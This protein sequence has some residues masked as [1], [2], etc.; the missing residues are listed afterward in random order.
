[1]SG[2]RWEAVLFD[3]DGTLADTVELILRCYR[4]TMRTHLGQSP[5]D[6]AWLRTMGTPLTEQFKEFARSHDEALAMLETYVTY[7]RSVHD[8]YVRP[9]PGVVEVAEGLASDGVPMAVVTSKRREMAVRTVERC[10]LRDCFEVLVCADDVDRPKPHPD[11]V[12]MALRELGSP[13]PGRVVFVGDSPFDLRAGREAAVRTAAALWGPFSREALGAEE[14]D[15]V[16][17]SVGELP[18]LVRE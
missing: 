10:G 9:Y 1:M 6:E 13:D 4:H 2:S 8:D 16:L 14:P 11:P 15:F 5:P 3:L 18:A 7:Q 12:L 17:A